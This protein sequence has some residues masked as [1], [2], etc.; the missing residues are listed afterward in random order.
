MLPNFPWEL[1]FG[2]L[3]RLHRVCCFEL[4]ITC[5]HTKSLGYPPKPSPS[6]HYCYHHHTRAHILLSPLFYCMLHFLYSFIQSHIHVSA[7]FM[8]KNTYVA[9]KNQTIDH[10]HPIIEAKGVLMGRLVHYRSKKNYQTR[11]GFLLTRRFRR[12][13][14]STAMNH[15]RNRNNRDSLRT[16]LLLCLAPLSCLISS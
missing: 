16:L 9:V 10:M 14:K 7:L 8:Q 1:R 4:Y 5:L 12:E 15:F 11:T 2:F 3:F 6:E 13:G